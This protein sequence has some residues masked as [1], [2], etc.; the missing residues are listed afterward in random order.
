MIVNLTPHEV[1]IAGRIIPA[2][3]EVARVSVSY[4]DLAP[5]EDIPVVSSVFGEIQG[6]PPRVPGT[7]YVVSG[8]V[9]SALKNTRPD[10]FSPDTG[11]TAMRDEAGKII[12]VTRLIGVP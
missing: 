11:S 6:L 5:H 4:I 2:S 1:V 7:V 8:M 9:R 3:G 10:V 12:G